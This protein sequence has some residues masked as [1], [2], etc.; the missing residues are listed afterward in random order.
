MP[1]SDAVRG[2]VPCGPYFSDVLFEY[3]NMRKYEKMQEKQ[4]T[5]FLPHGNIT[6]YAAQ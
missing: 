2:R 5:Y 6:K 3:K 1:K 4:L